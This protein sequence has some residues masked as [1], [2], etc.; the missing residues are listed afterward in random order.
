MKRSFFWA[1]L[2]AAGS[3]LGSGRAS[4]Q[5]ADTLSS[6]QVGPGVTYRRMVRL[7]G[8]WI[9][10]VIAVDLRRGD[11]TLRHVRAHDQLR[12]RE[13]P[14]EMVARHERAGEVVLAAVNGDFFDLKT[15]ENENNQVVDGEW[16]KGVKVT[17]SPFDTF[18]NPHA[19]FGLDSAN[20]PLID[21]FRF[22]GEARTAKVAFT[23]IALNAVP[24]GIEGTALFTP[25]FGAKVPVEIARPVRDLGKD[26][27]NAPSTA[28]KA[29]VRAVAEAPLVR[30]GSRGGA[31]LYVRRGPVSNLSGGY[32]PDDGAVLVGYGG[33]AK[34]VAGVGEGETLAVTL[35]TVPASPRAPLAQLIGGWPR[36]L[37]DGRNIA[38]NSAAEEGTIARNA[39]A[40]HPR[41]VVGFS[42]DS[43]TL[44]L[45][46]VDGRSQ[47]SVGMTTVE[48]ADIML[49]L[50]A[51][52]AMNFD[53]GGSTTMVVQ[54]TIVNSPTDPT[55]ER[56][57][58][59][60][61]LLV[62]RAVPAGKPR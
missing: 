35:R 36:I 39:M 33:T 26:P 21:Q 27:D 54:D 31:Q 45:V 14:T 60:A 48:L 22:D 32:I 19:Q 12:T 29:P 61:L 20:H 55:G 15:G 10:N 23:L 40:R 41:T 62:R 50:G 42:R 57:V 44:Y 1:L 24:T 58:G 51:W 30:A 53:G 38:A 18:A 47:K 11:L 59:N 25:R 34:D 46:T 5:R 4:A 6:R 16:W 2:L 37:R 9:V 3:A 49:E 56:E 8:P 28:P 17:D 13:R 52:Q 43:A 7:D